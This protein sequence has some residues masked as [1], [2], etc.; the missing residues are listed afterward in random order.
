MISAGFHGV[1]SELAP[2]FERA[3]GHHLITTR[4]PSLG[5]SPDA[6][7]RRLSR[8]ESADVVIL[9][10]GS[11]DELAKRGLVQGSSKILLARSQVGMVV[12]AGAAKPDIR[13]AEEFR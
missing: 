3:T 9:D 12:R 13:T 10:S 2:A 8:G 5:D 4:G 7:P 1:Y 11:A 6:I